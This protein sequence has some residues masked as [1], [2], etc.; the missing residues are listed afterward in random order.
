MQHKDLTIQKTTTPKDKCPL[1]QIVFGK[2]FTDH[3]FEVEW[4]KEGGWASPK[5]VPYHDL[6]IAP[7]CSVLHYAIQ[8]RYSRNTQHNQRWC[9][10]MFIITAYSASK[11]LRHTVT[12]K[13]TTCS[14]H[15]RTLHVS[16][17]AANVSHFLY[18]KTTF[19]R[20]NKIT[21]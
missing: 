16:T 3:M 8:V 7:S 15:K 13:K 9:T 10:Y 11:A 1:D 6:T 17:L 19:F 2:K 12:V 20:A 18:V 21:T 5:I 4:T 14:D